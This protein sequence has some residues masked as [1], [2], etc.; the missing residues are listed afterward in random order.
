ME[1]QILKKIFYFFENLFIFLFL[2]FLFFYFILP[3]TP[4]GFTH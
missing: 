2:I 1:F 4:S 3:V